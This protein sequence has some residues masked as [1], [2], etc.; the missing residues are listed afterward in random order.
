MSLRSLVRSQDTARTQ[1]AKH[2]PL[3]SRLLDHFNTMTLCHKKAQARCRKAI[4]QKKTA[5]STGG[6]Q[7]GT[8]RKHGRDVES[9]R[10]TYHIWADKGKRP[11]QTEGWAGTTS[12]STL[13]HEGTVVFILRARGKEQSRKS[14]LVI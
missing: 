8:K 1:I 5:N 9:S 14:S 4:R 12:V 6:R 7:G 13:E 2:K 3:A 11:I 10:I